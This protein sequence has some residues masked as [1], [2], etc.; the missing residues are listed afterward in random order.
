MSRRYSTKAKAQNM[1][2]QPDL[3]DKSDMKPQNAKKRTR[4]PTQ[5]ASTPSKAPAPIAP[6]MSAEKSEPQTPSKSAKKQSQ[7]ETLLS[8]E[9]VRNEAKGEDAENDQQCKNCMRAEAKNM[10]LC[11]SCNNGA[12]LPSRGKRKTMR[13]S[14]TERERILFFRARAYALSLNFLRC[15]RMRAIESYIYCNLCDRLRTK[16]QTDSPTTH[17][18]LMMQLCESQKWH[19]N[20]TSRNASVLCL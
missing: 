2:A 18:E 4:T 16:V 19:S 1:A 6:N 3:V 10:L 20:M 9:P 12:L 5:A 17:A 13:E 7:S 15:E 11:D 14:C 8:R